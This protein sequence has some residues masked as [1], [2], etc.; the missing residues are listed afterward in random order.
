MPQWHPVPEGNARHP[1]P[2][3]GDTLSCLHGWGLCIRCT[4]ERLDK[5]AAAAAAAEM[6]PPRPMTT[7]YQ[8]QLDSKMAAR[9]AAHRDACTDARCACRRQRTQPA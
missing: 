2:V 8:Q 4:A 5:R 7:G 9:M 6:P 3:C 1:C